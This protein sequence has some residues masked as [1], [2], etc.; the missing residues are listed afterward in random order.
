MKRYII[1]LT[2]EEREEL[3]RLTTT[4][5]H[6][7]LKVLR[8]RILIKADDGLVDE[9]IAEHLN[10]NVRTVERVRKRCAIE[11]VTAAL[12]PKKRPPKEPKVDGE[13]EARLIQLACSEAPDGR[14]RW[15]L[16][17]LA[18]KLVELGVIDSISHETVR[19]RL[20]K[21][22]VEAMAD[23]KILHSTGTQRCVRCGD[24]RRA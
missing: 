16:R 2:K 24:G 8:A 6:A 21:K 3:R 14:Q 4:G 1:N 5:R 23:S 15:T 13:A 19:Q 12:N 18:D 22:R 10:I 11:G 20:K 7:A 9:Q 17:L